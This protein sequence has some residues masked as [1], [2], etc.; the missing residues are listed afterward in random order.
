MIFDELPAWGLEQ[1]APETLPSDWPR[2]L[3]REWAFGDGRGAGVRVAIVDSGVDAGHPVLAGPLERA[4]AVELDGDGGF[5]V[6]ADEVGDVS[7]HGTACAGIVRALAPACELTSLRVLGADLTGG[8]EAFVAGLR[9]AVREGHHVVNLSLSTTKAQFAAALRE[10]ADEAYF[11]GCVLVASAHNMPVD[12]WPWRFAPVLSVGA[13]PARIRRRS[14][15][16]RVLRSSSTR[17]GWT[18]RSAGRA[19]TRSAR[20]A[21]RSPRRTSPGWRRACWER[22]RS[23]ARSRSRRCSVC[24]PTT[25]RGTRMPAEEDLRAAV[26]AGVLTAARGRAPLLQSVADVARAIFSA[27][28]SSIMLFDIASDELVFE[29]VSGEGAELLGRRIPKD[30]GIAGWVVGARDPIVV[31][32]VERDPRFAADFAR[33]AG[34]VP[35]GIMAAPLL[36]EDE[37]LGV[38]SILDR[39]QR[40]SLSLMELDL[41]GLFAHQAAVALEL[42][43]AGRRAEA[44]LRG[45][46]EL[47][48]LARLAAI[49]DGQRADRRAAATAL[50]AA[51][52][53]V[54]KPSV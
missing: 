41:L 46:G 1:T 34:Y 50:V 8:G 39:P 15:T 5:R 47:A 52:E 12:S 29:A 43:E 14:S 4:V 19:G 24:A 31:E 30:T 49:L 38:L 53:G 51:L 28:A 6:E 26:A 54:L 36:L 2:T 10:L 7:G 42:F 18:W 21:T 16:T 23:C 11:G 20:P 48:S 9:W 40:A 27:R 22:I 44:A 33:D 3:D 13:T 35:H 32:D 45:D 25:S 37:V 17:V